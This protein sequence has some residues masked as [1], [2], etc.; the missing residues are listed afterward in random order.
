M[1]TLFANIM[2][3]NPLSFK[4]IENGLIFHLDG[5]NT[6]PLEGYWTDLIGGVAFRIENGVERTNNGF[7]FPES[8]SAVYMLGISKVNLIA[9]DD[10]FTIEVVMTAGTSGTR[11]IFAGGSG[12]DIALVMSGGSL[13]AREARNTRFVTTNSVN[14]ST[15]S[16]T[17]Y[18]ALQNL[19]ELNSSGTDYWA[20][21]S[22]NAQVG[23]W[24][25]DRQFVGTI[26]D[27]RIY[28]RV[29]TKDEIRANQQIDII[30]YGIQV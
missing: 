28:N 4:Y 8:S 11:Y 10:T 19:I 13:T 27:I 30:R 7:I 23:G 24:R 25:T 15:Y 22:G 5:K 26:C 29:L 21:V 1:Y 3:K 14:L 6:G 16:I 20:A 18:Y 12:T 17:H 9:T 2:A